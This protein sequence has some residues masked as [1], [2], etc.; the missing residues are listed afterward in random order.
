MDSTLEALF[1]TI[2]AR[3]EEMPDG[4][5]TTVLFQSGQN[6]ICQK[7]GE[8][9]VEVVVA[10]LGESDERVLSEMADM[11]YHSL[12]LLAARGLTFADLEAELARRFKS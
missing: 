10:A 5:Y 7:I 2:Q 6:K 12:V 8:E 1:A 11:V 3:K 4:S 9:A